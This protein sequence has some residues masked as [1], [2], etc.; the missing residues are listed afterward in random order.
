MHPDG[1]DLD[2][3]ADLEWLADFDE[4]VRIGMGFRVDLSADDAR[5]GFDQLMVLGVRLSAGHDEG[6]DLVAS[7]FLHHQQSAVGFGLL[8]TGAAT[9]N[10][11]STSA[12]YGAAQDPDAAFDLAFGRL[13]ALSRTGDYLAR[14]DSQWLAGMPASLPAHVEKTTNNR[15]TDMGEAAMNTVLWP[16]TWGYF[17]ESML[18]PVLDQ[19]TVDITRWFFTHFV[20]GRGLAPAVRI[21]DQPYGILPVT[22]YSR[23]AWPTDRDWGPP[24]GLPHP[25][26]FRAFLARRLSCSPVR[27]PTGSACPARWRT[28]A[29]A[30]TRTQI[31][32]DVVG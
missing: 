1:S 32:L 29:R 24:F 21:G 16:A 6:S 13:P 31:L 3:G 10:T 17:L 22:A 30:T 8:R 18:R 4:A 9:N 2:F 25:G 14:L 15:N 26:D 12:A 11:E 28:S 7:L 19:S 5:D 23:M 27:A 20:T